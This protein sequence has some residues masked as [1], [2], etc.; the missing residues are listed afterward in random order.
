MKM[1]R[2]WTTAIA[3]AM[4]LGL[5]IPAF[6]P[7]LHAD[8]EKL[9]VWTWDP[10][11]NI[12]AMEEAAKIYK[13]SHPDF[14]LDCKE[15]PWPE[16]QTKLNTIVS[17][18][19]LDTLPDIFLCQ[20]NAYQKNV[21]AF[22]EIFTDLTDS[23]IDFSQFAEA[24]T[25][26]S[27]VNGRNYG[28]PF[29][30]G[31]VVAAYRTDYLEEAGF[32]IDDFTDITWEEFIE[33]GKVV[34]E[35]TK[36]PLI[37]STAETDLLMM[38]L[39]SAGASLFDSEGNPMIEGNVVLKQV[40]DLHKQMI[41]AKVLEIVNDWDQYVG[42]FTNGNVAGTINGCW[43]L[44]TV[45]TAED[46]A[47]KWKITNLPRLAIEG[48]TNYSNN[49]GSSWAVSK[50]QN[51]ALSIDFLNATFASSKKL[52]ETILP[53]SGAMATWLP[54]ADSDVY[55][56]PQ[57][58]FDGQK[59]YQLLTEFAGKVPLNNTGVFYYEAR[60]AVAVAMQNSINGADIDA[61]LA[62]AQAQVE[63][64]MHNAG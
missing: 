44:A 50:G 33:K 27:V 21:Q 20:D 64:Q 5:V 4:G 39:Q 55:G 57:A 9:T 54:M 7:T 8:E 43:I 35:K 32:T 18:N 24:K 6:T 23:G 59:V 49:G 42:S 45:Q 62:T 36:H 48:A 37:S 3:A 53:S 16:L 11:F 63:H 25:N 26:Y 61:E 28:V 51:E 30:N 40:I 15:V 13:E 19:A 34:Y 29:D 31:T 60:D 2:I 17:S 38:M 10:N 52:Y 47:G 41:D 58:Y 12:Y 56:E 22:P 1:K 46:Q 14:Q